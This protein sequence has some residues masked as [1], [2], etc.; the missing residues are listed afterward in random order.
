MTDAVRKYLQ[1]YKELENIA[2]TSIWAEKRGYSQAELQERIR[3]FA[4]IKEIVDSEDTPND[5]G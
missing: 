1:K 4:L 3:T 5:R 2:H